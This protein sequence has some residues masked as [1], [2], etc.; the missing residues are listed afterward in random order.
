MFLLSPVV[1]CLCVLF[2]IPVSWSAE[3]SD[4]QAVESFDP[5]LLDIR[6]EE[7]FVTETQVELVTSVKV[8]YEQIHIHSDTLT[9]SASPIRKNG[10]ALIERLDAR[11][12]EDVKVLCSTEH[13]ELPSV[14][15][16]TRILADVLSIK[17]GNM[18][19]DERVPFLLRLDDMDPMKGMLLRAQRWQRFTVTGQRFDQQS[20]YN[21]SEADRL[22]NGEVQG[23]ALY[24]DASLSLYPLL[25]DESIDEVAKNEIPEWFL[26]AGESILYPLYNGPVEQWKPVVMKGGF[27]I[28]WQTLYLKGTEL[29]AYSDAPLADGQPIV[30]SMRADHSEQYPLIIDTRT[31]HFPLRVLMYPQLITLTRLSITNDPDTTGTATWLLKI[32]QPGD[33]SGTMLSKDQWVPVEGWAEHIEC[34][35]IS[36]LVDG[37]L[38]NWRCKHI[39]WKGNGARPATV[40]RRD[41]R[42]PVRWSSQHLLMKFDEEGAYSGSESALD[43]RVQIDAAE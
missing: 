42:D 9:Y 28:D 23:I 20:F 2:C 36:D 21:L 6:S 14:Q 18:T 40:V 19:A 15:V 3:K 37:I 26:H 38:T 32:D 31:G 22:I 43:S 13:S 10:R 16:R 35:L 34:E 7:T 41:E 11:G 12:Q 39:T 24:T 29:T 27:Q 1:L 8:A 33:F 17:R 25:E 5:I 4:E 30:Y